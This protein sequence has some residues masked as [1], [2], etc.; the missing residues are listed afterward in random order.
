M[1]GDNPNLPFS[2]IPPQR[3][4]STQR[5]SRGC[6]TS[7]PGLIPPSRG[8]SATRTVDERRNELQPHEY[9]RAVWE[10]TRLPNCVGD[11]YI[12]LGWFLKCDESV[13]NTVSANAPGDKSPNPVSL[14]VQYPLG[15]NDDP[16]SSQPILAGLTPTFSI[17]SIPSPA[18][19]E[20]IPATER[21]SADERRNRHEVKTSVTF[22]TPADFFSNSIGEG[23]NGAQSSIIF[24]RG[25]LSAGWINNVGARYIIDPEFFCRHLDFRSPKETPKNFSIPALPSGS[26]FLIELPVMTIGID[27][28]NRGSQGKTIETMRREAE[29]AL[30]TY[31]HRL[32]TYK[33]ADGESMIRDFYVFDEA[34]FAM[35]QRISICMEKSKDERTFRLLVWLDSGEE[36]HDFGDPS[37]P[38]PSSPTS[39]SSPSLHLS[40]FNPRQNTQSCPWVIKKPSEEN[41]KYLPVI[42]HRHKIGL[43][44]HLLI[45]GISN[46]SARSAAHLPNDYGRSLHGTIMSQDAFYCLA[47]IF[48]FAASSQMEFLNLIDLKLDLYTSLPTEEDFKVL[49]N[50]KYSKKILYRYIQKTE[51]VLESIRNATNKESRWPRPTDQTE[52]ARVTAQNIEHDFEHL[53]KRAQTL[54]SRTTDAITVLLSSISIYESQRAIQQAEDMA[55]LT[56]LAFL[57][58]PL[59]FATSFFGMNFK[60][61]DGNKLS[62]WWW[63][64]GSGISLV[65]AILAY[66]LFPQVERLKNRVKNRYARW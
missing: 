23:L 9:A 7:P 25:H 14:V 66:Y 60:E 64:V 34:H 50:L 2:P 41:R 63:G 15:S 57:F 29:A 21:T 38:N 49:P 39:S 1:P 12:W 33:M 16:S 32:A 48:N 4:P 52:K 27:K 10:Y 37:S 3:S 47:E 65:I 26:S 19:G 43:K 45:D 11:N 59:S 5:P 6:G 54:H 35:E 58:V 61:L 40:S 20:P 22:N 17:T 62:V 13:P 8:T 56:F 46:P 18:S 42:L 30:E 28:T 55:K 44:S 24:L 36:F 51:R 53:L 31:R